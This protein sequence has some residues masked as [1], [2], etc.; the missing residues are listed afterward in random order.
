MGRKVGPLDAT[1]LTKDNLMKKL[2]GFTFQE[3]KE[4]FASKAQ[5]RYL[6]ATNTEAAEKMGRITYY[7]GAQVAIFAGLQSALFAML[8]NDE[9]VTEDKIASTKTYMLQSTSDSMLRGFGVQGAFISA[10]KNATLEFLKQQERG[11]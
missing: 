11:F 6:Y 10:F 3:L 5:Q 7:M 4:K 8:L 9:D 2:T 1:I